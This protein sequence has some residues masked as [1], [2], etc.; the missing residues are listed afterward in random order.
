MSRAQGYVF[1]SLFAGFLLAVSFRFTLI[2]QKEREEGNMGI[3][4]IFPSSP[5]YEW[6]TVL[7]H[8]HKKCSPHPLWWTTHSPRRFFCQLEGCTP[9]ADSVSLR[10]FSLAVVLAQSW[11]RLPPEDSAVTEAAGYLFIAFLYLIQKSR[12]MPVLG[13]I[14][15]RQNHKCMQHQSLS[16]SL[17]SSSTHTKNYQC[18]QGLKY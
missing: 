7:N 16:K 8:Q 1:H 13:F 10:S 18:C 17:I 9:C 12:W 11:A 14:P 3:G 5:R 4:K 2:Q 6:M 15:L